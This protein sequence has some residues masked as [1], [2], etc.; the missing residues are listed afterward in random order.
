M[1]PPQ[2]LRPVIEEGSLGGVRRLV[3]APPRTDIEHQITHTFY[4]LPE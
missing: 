3:C 4:T 2:V 1:H